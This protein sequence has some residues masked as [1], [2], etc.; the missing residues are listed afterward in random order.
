[1]THL[2]EANAID[3]THHD[4]HIWLADGPDATTFGRVPLP[5]LHQ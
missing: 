1:M 3:A 4:D 2:Q 5:M